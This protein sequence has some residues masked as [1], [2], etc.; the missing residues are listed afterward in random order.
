MNDVVATTNFLPAEETVKTFLN[1]WM[2]EH[3]QI[4]AGPFWTKDP[5]KIYWAMVGEGSVKGWA[6][7]DMAQD[8]LKLY[9]PDKRPVNS[10]I[11][12]A[13]AYLLACR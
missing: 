11:A 1:K 5:S 4:E 12:H 9:P 10:A 13:T 8:L 3:I 7:Y 6:L 2:P